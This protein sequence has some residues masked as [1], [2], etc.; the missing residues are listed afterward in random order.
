MSMLCLPTFS[1]RELD[2]LI[3][4]INSISV[5]GKKYLEGISANQWRSTVWVDDPTLPP[6]FSVVTTNMSES[7]NSMVGDA[8][9]G[10]WLECTNN[11]VRTMSVPARD[12]SIVG[13]EGADM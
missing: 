12:K 13:C 11:I 4:K 1:K 2:E 10:S 9:T 8:R 7:A 3:A 5:R 6:R